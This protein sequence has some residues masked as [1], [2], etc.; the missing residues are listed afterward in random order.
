MADNVCARFF[1][2]VIA[3]LGRNGI[4]VEGLLAH[5]RGPLFGSLTFALPI[6]TLGGLKS[7]FGTTTK[8]RMEFEW[9]GGEDKTSYEKRV[10]GI[11]CC[12]GLT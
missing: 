6:G 1:D 3:K 12:S 2:A 4:V 7:P 10:I 9:R 5:V 11:S 8:S